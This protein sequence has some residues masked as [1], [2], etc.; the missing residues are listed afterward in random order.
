L[1][2]GDLKIGIF[3]VETSTNCLN[4]LELRV[5]RGFP[6]RK[7]PKKAIIVEVLENP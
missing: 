6:T 1:H 7:D 3:D 5:Q 2:V 4:R